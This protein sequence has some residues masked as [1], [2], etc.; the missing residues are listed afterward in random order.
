MK[1]TVLFAHGF[2]VMKD[3]RGMFTQIAEGLSLQGIDPVLVDLN[4]RDATGNI[5]LNS[6]SAQVDILRRARAEI[7]EGEVYLL[8]HSQGCVI[9]ALAQLPQI[10]K[11]IFLAPPIGNNYTKTIEYFSKNPLTTIDME[12]TSRLARRDGTFTIVPPGYW[13]ERKGLDIQK[14]YQEY[15]S[16]NVVCVVKATQDEIVSNEGLEEIFRE[17]EIIAVE[18]GHDFKGEAREPLI[19]LCGRLV[20]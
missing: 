2:G 13:A 8:C 14:L 10:H 5:V 19:A 16:K 1:K 17:A 9:A 6:F 12:G 7:K 20:G 18:A 4:V 3:A 15:C 11:T